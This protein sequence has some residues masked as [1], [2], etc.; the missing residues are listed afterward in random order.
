MNVT[1]AELSSLKNTANRLTQ[2]KRWLEAIEIYSKICQLDPADDQA[3]LMLGAL[4]GHVGN[5]DRAE[6]CCHRIIALNPDCVEAHINLGNVLQSQQRLKEALDSYQ[7]ALALNAEI[8]PL[9]FNIGVIQWK[10]GNVKEA[11]SC[12][13][14]S[15]ALQPDNG[16][17]WSSLATLLEIRG[18]LAESQQCYEQALERQPEDENVLLRLGKLLARQYRTD[19]ALQRFHQVLRFNP[20]SVDALVNIALAFEQRCRFEEAAEHYEAA[21]R[22][23]PRN[24]SILSGLLH[25]RQWTCHWDDDERL[26]QRLNQLYRE[27]G[28]EEGSREEPF[29]NIARCIDLKRNLEV[30]KAASDAIEQK[31]AGSRCSFLFNDRDKSQKRKIRIAYL[32]N[33]FHDHPTAHLMAGMFRSHDHDD[34][35]VSAYAYD[36]DDSSEYRA[37]IRSHCDNFVDISKLGFEEAAAR[38]HADRMDILIDL[39]GHTGGA[40]LEIC[41]LRPAPVQVTY[42]GF[43][44]TSGARFFDYVIADR[45]VIPEEHLPFYSEQVAYMPHTYQ[46]N[47]DRQTMPKAHFDRA[48]F[49]LPDNAIV[50]C[51]FNQ[52]YKIDPVMFDVWMDILATVPG[53]VLWLMPGNETAR[54]N[55][56]HAAEKRSLN[57]RR[58]IFAE[59]IPKAQH[60]ARLQLADIMLDTR[61]YNGHTTTSDALWAGVPVI[62]LQGGHFASRVS[63]SL[64]TAIQ[65]PELITTSLDDYRQLAI[66]LGSNVDELR[67]I[68]NKLAEQRL[69]APLFDS[70]R[71]TADFE[72]ALRHMWQ[73]YSTSGEPR[74]FAVD[75]VP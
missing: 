59:R 44:G 34:F 11:E 63:A 10:L 5:I 54:N 42:L 35:Y 50:F 12:F 57:P 19:E 26:M 25:C 17:A 67:V 72:T 31:V 22:Y 75:Q 49:S 27:G 7:R 48:R 33:D 38:I 41:A 23:Q 55:L 64:L 58:L 20:V 65:M 36:Q 43:P 3:W 21:L 73:I 53:S 60:L 24:L 15:I 13:R 29:A 68:R 2:Q 40:R 70:S 47:D 39:K 37:L 9:H 46:A 56:M 18:C 30:A 14:K 71:F 8:G 1:D 51:S 28:G 52:S 74:S 32:S 45:V 4:H 66:R 62:A 16:R 61:I 6:E 69:A